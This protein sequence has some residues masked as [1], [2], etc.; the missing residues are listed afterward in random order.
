[1]A[2]VAI[3]TAGLALAMNYGVHVGSSVAFDSFCVPH[4]V[5]DIAQSFIATSSPVCAFLLNTMSM[6]Q[7]NFSVALTTTI[8][9]SVATFLRV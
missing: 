7:N 5:W 2:L 8:A 4:S 3:K 1:M 9:A 6:T